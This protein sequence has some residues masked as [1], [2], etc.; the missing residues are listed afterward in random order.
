MPIAA[1]ANNYKKYCQNRRNHSIEF[2]IRLN[3]L[4]LDFEMT[5]IPVASSQNLNTVLQIT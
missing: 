2:L 4:H 1:T 5:D 3:K